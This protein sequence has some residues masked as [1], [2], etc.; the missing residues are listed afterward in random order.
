MDRVLTLQV[1]VRV[2]ETGSFSKAAAELG[3]TQPTATKAV[4]EAERRLGA[5]LLHRTTRGVTATEVGDV[6]YERCKLIL[7]DLEE[8][9]N[10]ATLVQ[11]DKTGTLR[12]NTSV[13]FGRRVVLPLVLAYMRDHPGL[14]VDLGFDDRFVS[15]V[16]EGVDLA[17]RMGRLADSSLGA[18]YLGTNP[19]ML[20]AAPGYLA[21]REPPRVPRDLVDHDCLVY[22]SVQG[23]ARWQWH[24]PSGEE[25]E[26][27]LVRGPLRS[28]NL[29]AVLAACRDGMGLAILPWYVAG[30]SVADGSLV[31][32]LDDYSL[33]SQQIHAVF[34]SPRLVPTKVTAFIGWLQQ[35]LD[36]EW[37]RRL[38]LGGGI[39]PDRGA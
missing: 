18:R 12:I 27:V 16:E 20:A 1:Y 35:Q 11:R 6:Y 33:P 10:L 22:S 26:A 31:A 36:G 17:I 15:L 2:V 7:R 37:W 30:E 3:M 34:P 25:E 28:N 21:R 5:R 4:A 29:S 8:A 39:R 32:L 14:Q 13:A 24:G 19:W 38:P 9:E 23:D